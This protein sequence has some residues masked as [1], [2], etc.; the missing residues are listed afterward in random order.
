MF[1]S[2][3]AGFVQEDHQGLL[4][5][6][7]GPEDMA[8]HSKCNWGAMAFEAMENWTKPVLE[9]RFHWKKSTR[10]GFI[11][12]ITERNTGPAADSGKVAE[13]DEVEEEPS[14]SSEPH[15]PIPRTVPHLFESTI[16]VVE[17]PLVEELVHLNNSIE[18][19]V[20]QSIEAA[21]K[22]IEAAEKSNRKS[23]VQ[24]TG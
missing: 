24:V 7:D 12:P 6:V 21:E 10:I 18:S 3:S 5:F 9:C 17:Q 23:D 11:A 16:G 15:T 1:T 2:I 4:I 19:D 13:G 8:L 14:S 22:S 20:P